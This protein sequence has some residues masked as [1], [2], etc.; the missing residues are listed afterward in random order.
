MSVSEAT[1]KKALAEGYCYWIKQTYAAGEHAAVLEAAA[2][3]FQLC[4]GAGVQT[5]LISDVHMIAAKVYWKQRRLFS[6]SLS[7]ARAVL[8]RPRVLGHLL[9]P[10]LGPLR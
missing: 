2:E 9:R 3:M 4:E 10:L 7:V 5:R 8:A 6:S 1:Q